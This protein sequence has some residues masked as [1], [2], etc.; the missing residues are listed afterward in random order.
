MDKRITIIVP[1]NLIGIGGE[2]YRVGG[3]ADLCPP[4]LHAMQWYPAEG[5]APG[6]GEEE[7]SDGNALIGSLD[8]YGAALT[9]WEA[10]K[11]AADAAA[12]E[13]AANEGSI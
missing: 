3:L 5:A 2:F 1:D 9:A 11:D 7:F 8:G 13:A 12:A 4:G 6:W 10:E